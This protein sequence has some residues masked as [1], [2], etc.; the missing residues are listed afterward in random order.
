MSSLRPEVARARRTVVKVCG[1]TNVEDAV[2]ALSAGADWLGF[3]VHAESPR[4]IEPSRAADIVAAL[5]R[6]VVVAVVADAGPDEALAIARRVGAARLQ[7][8]RAD[9]A[10]WPADFPLPC[11][12]ASG[13]DAA[14]ALRDAL[15]AEPHLVLLFRVQPLLHLCI[16]QVQEV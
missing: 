12:F 7:L 16:M 15:P 5:G 1:L 2:I 14:G 3:V 10:A 4:A 13:V 9:P 6:G 8:H 11:A